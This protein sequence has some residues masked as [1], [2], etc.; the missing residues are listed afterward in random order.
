MRSKGK[1]FVVS[2]PIGNLKD[3]TLRALEVLENSHVVVCEDT[4]RGKSLLHALN[5]KAKDKLFISYHQHSPSSREREILKFIEE[6][7]SVCLITDSGTPGISDP[8][9]KIIKKCLELGID[10]VPVPGPSAVLCALVASGA[11]YGKG[12][13]FGGYLPSS[14]KKKRK[15][16]EE[17]KGERCPFIFFESPYRI[18]ETLD[19]AS[20]V[21]P[22]KKLCLAREMTKIHEEFIRGS[23]QEVAKKNISGKGEFTLV[24]Y[25]E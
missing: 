11:S 5:I 23:V 9:E 25:E 15:V 20:S 7:K 6:G 10:V 18:R 4:R 17:I 13:R 2:T 21:I 19:M 22:H 1:I 14:K 24:F 8:G 3:I 16:I 12:F